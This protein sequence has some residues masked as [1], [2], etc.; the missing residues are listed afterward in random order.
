MILWKKPKTHANRVSKYSREV[1][2]LG[3]TTRTSMLKP[4]RGRL[5]LKLKLKTPRT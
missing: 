2:T 1:A 4:R 5:N 3:D